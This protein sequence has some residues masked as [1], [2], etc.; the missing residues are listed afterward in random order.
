MPDQAP[1]SSKIV[2]LSELLRRRERVRREG[3]TLVHC[4]GCFDIV[5]P[6]H[7]RHLQHARRQGDL[8]LVSITTD[9]YVAKGD[10]RP[11]FDE[12]LRAENLAALDCVDLVLVNDSPTASELLDR[13][14]P[15][16]F[17]KGREYENNR[18]PRFAAERA[19]V[20][21]HGGRVVF[22]SG[23]VVFSSTA[24]VDALQHRTRTDGEREDP[25]LVRLRQLAGLA[26]LSMPTLRSTVDRFRGR[27]VVVFGEVIVDTY[28]TCDRPE[29]ASDSPVMSLRPLE[30]VSFD[31][32]AAVIARHLAALGA[33]PALVTALPQSPAAEALKERL[34]AAGVEV[35]SILAD[36]RPGGQLLEK[37]RM[38]VGGQK[39][40]KLDLVRSIQYDATTREKLLGLA[41]GV[42]YG[43]DAAI[44]ADFGLGLLTPRTLAELSQALRSRVG[45]IA[46]DV[47]GKR[48]S[49]LS[50][51]DFDLLTPSEREL[52]EAVREHDESLNAAAWRLMALTGAR[53]VFATLG[54]EGVIAFDRLPSA[55]ADP[56]AEGRDPLKWSP[57]LS[58]EHVPSLAGE[59]K[60]E[61][62]CGD[63]LLAASTLALVA[64][65]GRLQAA[66][67]GSA[68]AAIQASWFGNDA[69]GR[70]ELI[71]VLERLDRAA[72]AV[73][74]ERDEPRLLVG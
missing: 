1:A 34:G 72:L 19:A 22:S 55:E 74:L 13:V 48:A 20:E 68:A 42:A 46:G 38:V 23:D 39:V 66:Y 6:G 11:L 54:P 21:R 32:G 43:A 15:D 64:G 62:G 7:I 73:R 12:R 16:V 24:L 41:E 5:H 58:G 17:I 36:A 57:K 8:L 67:L 18:D 29:V 35:H 40:L 65:V 45:V 53:H 69:V 14:R 70:D 59:V 28:V 37:Q 26:D 31:G 60:D 63:A 33:R 4:H 44:I 25:R 61:L 10:G 52:R 3:R 9:A 27:R 2:S 50:M 49:L 47:S 71:R 30:Q 51:R 56:D